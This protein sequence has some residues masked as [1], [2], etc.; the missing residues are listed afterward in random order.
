MFHR[1]VSLDLSYSY[2]YINNLPENI[3]TNIFTY[4]AN[5]NIFNRIESQ[6][7]IDTLQD[8]NYIIK[9]AEN[10]QCAYIHQKC[11]HISTTRKI[12][13][14]ILIIPSRLWLIKSHKI[15]KRLKQLYWCYNR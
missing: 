14:L 15:S 3:K 8:H 5:T 4:A 12:T 6:N 7:D 13:I 10:G 1:E 11:Q 2:P 9:W